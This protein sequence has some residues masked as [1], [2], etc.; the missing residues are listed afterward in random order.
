MLFIILRFAMCLQ[1]LKTRL[2]EELVQLVM[3]L[4]PTALLR[5]C[6]KKIAMAI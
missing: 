4:L 3:K 1:V 6:R 2:L 5:Y